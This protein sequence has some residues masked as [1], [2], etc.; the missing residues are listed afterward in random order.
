MLTH[1]NACGAKYIQSVEKNTRAVSSGREF[2]ENFA[3]MHTVSIIV[4]AFG[5]AA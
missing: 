4:M 5:V 1:R 3:H 2:M